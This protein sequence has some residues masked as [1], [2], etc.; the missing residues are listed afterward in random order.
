MDDE[1][2]IDLVVLELRG[3]DRASE[4]RIQR[5]IAALQEGYVGRDVEG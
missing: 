3:L 1:E 2:R 4:E 5:L